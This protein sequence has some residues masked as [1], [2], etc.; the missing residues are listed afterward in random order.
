MTVSRAADITR[1]LQTDLLLGIISDEDKDKLITWR[2][3][4]KALEAVDTS[5]APEINWPPTPVS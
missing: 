3:Y 5:S 4:I 1:E 2:T